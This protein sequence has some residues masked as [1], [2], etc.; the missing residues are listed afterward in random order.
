MTEVR[1]GP[2]FASEPADHP[3]YR[4]DIDGL[5]AIAVT[6][7]VA[8]H[9]A[10]GRLH[11]GF[12]GVDIFFVISGYLITSIIVGGLD[13]DRFSFVDFYV[14]RIRRIFPALALVL[15][16]CLLVGIALFTGDELAALG[17]HVAAGA[18]FVSNLVLW[19]ESGY[20]DA[21]ADFK[22]LLHLWSLGVEEQFYIVWPALL[23]LAH[24]FGVRGKALFAVV[25]LLGTASFAWSVHQTVAAPIAAYYS[26]LSRFW[27]PM[28]GA[29]L[30]VAI[31][32]HSL[33]LSGVASDA[34][35]WLG[36]ALIGASLVL[37]HADQPYPGFRAALPTLGAAA[38][39]LA[40]SRAWPNRRLLAT[41]PMVWIGLISYPLY[42]WHWPLIVLPRILEGTEVSQGKRFVAVALA[43]P[44]AW[45][46]Y[47]VV[48][49]P[50]RGRRGGRWVTPMLCGL[51]AAIAAIGGWAWS[52][53][54]FGGRAWAPRV[55]NAGEIGAPPYFA[56]VEA[57]YYPCLP[58]TIRRL[59]LAGETF[60]RCPQSKTG[61]QQNV[62]LIGDS[63]AEHLFPG[64]AEALPARNV[65]FYG[66]GEGL[67]FLSNPD[68]SPVFDH[69]ERSPSI[70]AVIVA[71]VWPRKLRPLAVP[72]WRADL[73][74]T[75]RRLR[76]AGK[77]VYLAD[78]VPSFSFLPSRCKFDGRLGTRTQCRE[79]DDPRQT[80][81][82]A[83]FDAI[84]RETGAQRIALHPLFCSGGTCAMADHG[85]LLYRDDHH[86]GL[87]GSRRAG[88]AIA[89]AMATTH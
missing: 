41:R 60:L 38:L 53:D 28:I 22:P 47:A 52:S 87:A 15:A 19:S 72:A 85:V 84:G 37:I 8:F 16:A 25:G 26:Q 73:T 77:T 39:I 67:P 31:R 56:Y 7:V 88:A 29:V 30:A 50:V 55:V 48:E 4:P 74:A 44:L 59:A 42:L 13:A 83:V 62:A 51:V 66:I 71:A 76:A 17:K 34:V 21:S 81:Y 68:F 61:A 58:M 43:V 2:A 6:A 12:V 75:I 35:A 78:D 18:G 54:G 36:L 40:G 69:V 46:T 45:L 80:A 11:G 9:A 33:R 14:R 24:R 23:F 32:R 63:H 64:L 1:R 86:L 70:K 3:R 79:G 57:H 27:E 49:K 5:R 20:F 65:V 89:Q 10:P 82:V